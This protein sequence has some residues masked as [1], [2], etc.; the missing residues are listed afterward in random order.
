[1]ASSGKKRTTMA[2]LNRE[3]KL[4]DKR[5]EKQARK[6]AR[7]FSVGSDAA[8]AASC[9]DAHGGAL[10]GLDA[11]VTDGAEPNPAGRRKGNAPAL[12]KFV[13]MLQHHG[14]TLSAREQAHCVP[15]ESV[16][17]KLC[18]SISTLHRVSAPNFRYECNSPAVTHRL[19][20]ARHT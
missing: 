4:R 12:R 2:K 18:R 3:S 10:T 6:A 9:V 5:A 1:M 15:F 8:E 11:G 7:K 16:T 13:Q 14:W 19:P 20:R 17:I